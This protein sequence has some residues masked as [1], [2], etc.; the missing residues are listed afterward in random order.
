VGRPRTGMRGLD[1][2]L[3]E[4]ARRW[5]EQTAGAQGLPPRVMDLDVLRDVCELLGI[6]EP[7]SGGQ[8]RQAGRKREGSKRL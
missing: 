4:A 5:A 1:D 2:E 8:A 7:E 6:R 3:R